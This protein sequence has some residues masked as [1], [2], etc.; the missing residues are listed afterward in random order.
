MKVKAQSGTFS[1]FSPIEQFLQ[2]SPPQEKPAR[3]CPYRLRSS[4]TTGSW[5]GSQLFGRLDFGTLIHMIGQSS[6]F[7]FSKIKSVFK[8]PLVY[9]HYTESLVCPEHPGNL[10]R[11][12]KTFAPVWSTMLLEYGTTRLLYFWNF[13]SNSE[14]LMTEI[15][16]NRDVRSF[17]FVLRFLNDSS[18]TFYFCFFPSW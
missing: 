9:M 2:L 18:F 16:E 17:A 12:S 10:K 14:F 11:T 5:T 3:G 4:A 1:Q 6:T 8:I 15:H 7:I 13:W